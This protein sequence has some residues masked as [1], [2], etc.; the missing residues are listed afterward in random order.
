MAG[1]PVALHRQIR[2]SDAARARH[3]PFA[4]GELERDQWMG[5]MVQAMEEVDVPVELRQP[6]R[7]ALYKTADWMRNQPT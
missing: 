1:R 5:C 6:L 4:I 3:L 7:D 2:A